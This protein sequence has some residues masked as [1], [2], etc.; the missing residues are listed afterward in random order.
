MCKYSIPLT[1][2]MC[3]SYFRNN[4]TGAVYGAGH[5]NPSVAPDFTPV[6]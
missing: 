1:V 6:L 2:P 5:A 4:M 3:Y